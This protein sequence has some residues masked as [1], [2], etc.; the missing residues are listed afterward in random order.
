MNT[1]N[2]RL[3]A[4]VLALVAVAFALVFVRTPQTWASSIISYSVPKV[5]TTSTIAVGPNGVTT[6][7]ATSSACSSRLVSTLGKAIMLSFTGLLTPTALIGHVQ[8]A[9]TTISYS[10][11][12][13]GCGA[14]TAFGFDAS[15]TI[16]L[17]AFSQ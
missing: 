5:A 17:T 2:L 6:L 9:S 11:D 13:Y 14:I 8:A 10:N 12:T 7:F 16:T 1:F 4:A 3:G 15:T